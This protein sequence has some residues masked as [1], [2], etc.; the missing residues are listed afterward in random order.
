MNS[1]ARHAFGRSESGPNPLTQ[2]IQHN[3]I[4][5]AVALGAFAITRVWTEESLPSVPYFTLEVL[6]WAAAVVYISAAF[7]HLRGFCEACFHQPYGGDQAAE[8]H[9]T[10]LQLFHWRQD[11]VGKWIALLVVFVV[12]V[13]F[14][15]TFNS[16]AMQSLALVISYSAL[17][18]LGHKHRIHSWLRPWCPQCKDDGGPDDR[19]VVPEP[20]PTAVKQA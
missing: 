3:P 2:W 10:F 1:V 7:A 13:L 6:G 19:T 11:N 9:R 16:P 18:F 14:I 5:A 4:K 17:A 12:G 8:R 20:G 15:M